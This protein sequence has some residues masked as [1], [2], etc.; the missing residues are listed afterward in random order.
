MKRRSGRVGI[1]SAVILLTS[2]SLLADSNKDWPQFRGES[3]DGISPESG[4]L[5]SWPENGP[6]EIWR[7][8]IG[9]GFSGISIV[10]GRLYTMYAEKPPAAETAEG[11]GGESSESASSEE[12]PPPKTEYAAAYDAATGKQLWRTAIGTYLVTEFGNG[13]RST[14]T[15]D[16][17]TVYVLGAHG[18]LAALDTASGKRRWE[19]SLGDEFGSERPYWGFSGSALIE[20]DL[21]L[22]EGGGPDGKS[23]AGL[24]KT[25]G[26]VLWTSGKANGAG[27]SSPLAISM[28]DQRQFVYVTGGA[29]RAIDAK[30]EEIWTH[31]WPPGE[32]HAMPIFIPP[33]KIFASGT[34]G[35]GASLVR[36]VDG[37]E[38]LQAE[39]L[40]KSRVMRNHFSS[41][42]VHAG[43]LYGFDNATLKSVELDSGEQKWAKRGFGKGSLI[44]ADGHLLVLSDRGVLALVEA[45]SESYVEKGRLQA[46]EG[47]CWTAPTLAGGR[48]YLRGQEEMVSYDLTGEGGRADAR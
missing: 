18:E 43:H 3:R 11:S 47:L 37:G 19:I 28:H 17:D 23:Y 14:P 31:P 21:L 8:P 20:N 38:S 13:P 15:V 33:D 9:E 48:L 30:G 10:A 24:D 16:G 2:V 34:E 7:Q 36:I 27:Y 46:L 32:T 45:T 25:T 22:V 39:E 42:L 6:A 35:I 26:K 1:L 44:Y 41:S 12:A 5:D 4:L 29:L 40:W